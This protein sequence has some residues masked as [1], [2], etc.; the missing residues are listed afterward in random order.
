MR[1]TFRIWLPFPGLSSVIPCHTPIHMTFPSGAHFLRLSPGCSC[2]SQ[3]LPDRSRPSLKAWS[4]SILLAQ[5][6]C[7]GQKPS[8]L[9]LRGPKSQFQH[10]LFWRQPGPWGVWWWQP[11]RLEGPSQGPGSHPELYIKCSETV[12]RLQPTHQKDLL[13]LSATGFMCALSD[14]LPWIPF[15]C[16]LGPW[17]VSSQAGTTPTGLR[18]DTSKA[19]NSPRIAP[20][21]GRGTEGRRG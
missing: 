20:V 19:G 11:A 12:Q 7:R 3:A 6:A 15:L 21:Q 4:D 13:H 2:P 5:Q 9:K 14:S 17:K 10:R 8:T 18:G 1:R 16:I